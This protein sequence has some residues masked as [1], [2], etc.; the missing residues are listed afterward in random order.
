MYDILEPNAKNKKVETRILVAVVSVLVLAVLVASNASSCGGGETDST[1]GA[2]TAARMFVRDRL[3]SP[4]S[5]KFGTVSASSLGNSRY[6]FSGYVDAQNSFG[7]QIR[8][9]FS[10]VVRYNDG[11]WILESISM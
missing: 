6:S 5:A 7:A 8:T 1:L 10:G 4:S 2:R 11:T 9:R 3:K